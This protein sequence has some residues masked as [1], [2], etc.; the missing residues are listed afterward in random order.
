MDGEVTIGSDPS[1]YIVIEDETIDRQHAKVVFNPDVGDSY[2]ENL[3]QNH[4]L[5]LNGKVIQKR[6]DKLYLTEDS[7]IHLFNRDIILLSKKGYSF[8][9]ETKTE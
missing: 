9:F 3:S 7:R 2:L 4:V 8:I 1:S 5:Y 6:G